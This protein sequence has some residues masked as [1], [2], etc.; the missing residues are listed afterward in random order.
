MQA[1][2]FDLDGTLVDSS[3]GITES[4]QHTF[5][6]LKVP[7]PDLETI[8]SFMGPPLI[9]S[10]EATL[11]ETLVDQ[12]VTIYRQYY[13]EK[14]QYKTTLF[15]QIVDALESLKNNGFELY[16]TTSK[17]EPVALQMCQ[18]L[19]IA[20]Y[21][22]GIYGSSPVYVHKADVIQHTLSINNIPKEEALIIG[23][24]KF[25]LI[26]GQTV[27][28][29]TMAVTWGFGNLEELLLYSPDYICHSPLDILE[30][31]KK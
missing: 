11:P 8:R 20:D 26:G 14:G 12:A 16:V 2:F 1:S 24:T 19:G 30:T 27:G 3:K 6:T 15:P 22:N 23:D 9:S 29:K 4:F 21:F 10:F 13:H 25:D 7:Q 28:I 5:D 31:L 18:D 17:Y